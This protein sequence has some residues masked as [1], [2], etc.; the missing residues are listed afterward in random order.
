MEDTSQSASLPNLRNVLNLH[1]KERLFLKK[2]K[3]KQRKV[4]LNCSQLSDN[5]VTVFNS[6][7]YLYFYVVSH[8]GK[9]LLGFSL[10]LIN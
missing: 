4:T 8:G 1:Q 2:T 9:K 7:T 5:P 3:I 6:N 10:L